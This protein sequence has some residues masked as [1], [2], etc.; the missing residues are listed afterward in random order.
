M[1]Q[2]FSI[3]TPSFNQSEFIEQTIHSVLDQDYPALEYLILDGGSTDGTAEI[4][5]T[6]AESH[7]DTVW[8]RSEKDEGQVAAIN[9][10]LQKA[11]GDIVAF[12][13]SDDTYLPGAFAAVSRYF[14]EHPDVQWAVGDCEVSE[15]R[16]AWTFRLKWLAPFHRAAW[17]L[18]IFNF[19]NQPGVFLRREFVQQVGPFNPAYPLAFDYEYWLRCIRRS[20]PGRIDRK[21]AFFRVQP[22]SKSSGSYASQF[23]ESLTLARS[24]SSSSFVTLIQKI[25][26]W[27]AKAVYR[28]RK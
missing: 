5:R 28:S 2:K 9:E 1:T 14:E 20:L 27:A 11:A 25:I 16:L 18:L 13:N 22:A 10:G 12:I 8:F 6:Q 21:L 23:E 4:V 26:A 17:V 19:I 7:P 24:Y 15:P 3:I